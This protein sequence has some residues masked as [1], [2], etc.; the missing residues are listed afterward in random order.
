MK[1]GFVF[2]VCLLL[3]AA[4]VFAGGGAQ[5]AKG[6][7]SGKKKVAYVARTLSD[8][9]AAWLANEMVKH[10]AAYSDTYTLD[11]LDSQGDA[12]KTNTHI[13]NCITKGYD[14]VIIQPND[15]E[16]QRPYA[17][18]LLDN[19]IKVITTNAKIPD[20]KGSSGVDADPYEQGKVLAVD[21]V[22]KVP[23]N[24]RAVLLNCL[25]G[26]LHTTA[27]YKAFQAEFVA[28]RPDVTILADAILERA[29][30]ADAMAK[31]EDWVQ[32]FG[33]FDL[34]LTSADVLGLAA[35]EVT[36]NNPAFKDLLIYGVDGLAG[37]ML[38][39][40]DGNYT[41]SCFQNAAQ[42]AE[43]N[44]KAAYELLTG[45]KTEVD[46]AISADLITKE[47]VDEYLKIAVST[48]SLTQAE[49]D[50]HK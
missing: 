19:G 48:G 29:S 30:E 36:K 13:E 16:L 28:K 15:G 38:A 18:R 9:F 50:A 27:R 11:V 5:G 12:E 1:K 22:K 10:A 46:Y 40:K 47:N 49:V 6:A 25:P 20:L 45:A 26:N 35:L 7:G 41:G 2:S 31:F 24:G 42:L 39:I 34:V 32:S 44:T 3:S 33:K 8:P 4:V 21:A 14:L 43:L 23:R 17:Q 37:A